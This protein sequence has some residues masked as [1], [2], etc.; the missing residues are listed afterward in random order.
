MSTKQPYAKGTTV[1]VEKSQTEIQRTL[2]RYGADAFGFGEDTAAH[3]A[4]VTFRAHG[5]HV[6]FD[7]PLPDP[8]KGTWATKST[9]QLDAERRRRWRALAAAIKSLLECVETG[10]LTFEEAFAVKTVLPSGET[11][12]AWLEPQVAQVY[13]TGTMPPLLPGGDG[14]HQLAP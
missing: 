3:R 5:R 7:L 14:Q 2:A 4:V 10:I 9:N 11:V 13:E 1:S 6:R 8:S 12:G